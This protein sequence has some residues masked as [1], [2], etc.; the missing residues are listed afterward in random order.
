MWVF[1]LGKD[2]A[3]STKV[4]LIHHVV[5]PSIKLNIKGELPDIIDY[6][7]NLYYYVDINECHEAT[8]LKIE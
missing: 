3:T 7:G 1:K 2:T 6:K 8:V 5:Q 4:Y